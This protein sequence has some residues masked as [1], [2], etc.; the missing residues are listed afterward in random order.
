MNPMRAIYLFLLLAVAVAAAACSR[1]SD[2]PDQAAGPVLI[3]ERRLVNEAWD[4]FSWSPDGRKV[5]LSRSEYQ[6]TGGNQPQQ[7]DTPVAI[8]G[9]KSGTV[10]IIPQL[11]YVPLWSPDGENILMRSTTSARGG[12]Q[13]RVY[14][15]DSNLSFTLPD[16]PAHTCGPGCKWS[17]YQDGDCIVSDPG[18]AYERRTDNPPAQYL[19]CFYFRW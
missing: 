8:A 15:L 9:T 6:H 13:F 1:F 18:I 2:G 10:Q 5:L 7:V 3:S 12:N 11:G 16:N 14:S 17:A 19:N 4:E